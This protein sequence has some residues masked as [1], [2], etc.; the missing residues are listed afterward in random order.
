[1]TEFSPAL[2]LAG[3]VLRKVKPTSVSVWVATSQAYDV[4]LDVYGS[5]A[6]LKRDA[7]A[8][9]GTVAANIAGGNTRPTVKVG[10]LLH[11]T[12]VT[13]SITGVPPDTVRRQLG[14]PIGPARK[15]RLAEVSATRN[16][17]HR[18]RTP[19]A[20]ARYRAHGNGHLE[21]HLEQP[22]PRLR[23]ALADEA[24]SNSRRRRHAP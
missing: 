20:Q 8:Q 17:I 6:V 2:L 5:T 11:I 18:A 24:R 10:D 22:R 14:H 19:A 7:D 15:S 9:T 12:V 1:M 21:R 3:P 4:K 16:L 23:P 13:A